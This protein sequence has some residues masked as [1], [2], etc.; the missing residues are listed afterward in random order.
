MHD[1]LSERM[2]TT[3][4][5]ATE[6]ALARPGHSVKVLD[7]YDEYHPAYARNLGRM[8]AGRTLDVGDYERGI[9]EK[10]I[11]IERVG[12]V[13]VGIDSEGLFCGVQVIDTDGA[14]WTLF[15]DGNV[16]DSDDQQVGRHTFTSS[17][18]R[19]A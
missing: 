12:I 18:A 3:A 11:T 1:D 19:A 7:W 17:P 15:D 16:S 5:D 6:A 4:L 10:T 9:D 14:T 2:M 8:L 13:T